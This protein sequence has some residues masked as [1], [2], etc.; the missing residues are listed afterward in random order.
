MSHR[1]DIL[2]ID[3]NDDIF[4]ISIDGAMATQDISGKISSLPS[5][6]WKQ[7]TSMEYNSITGQLR[8]NYE[9]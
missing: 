8:I 7:I 6:N 4:Q 2:Y 3:I 1:N 9:S 5:G